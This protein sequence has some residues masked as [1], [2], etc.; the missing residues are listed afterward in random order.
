MTTNQSPRVAFIGS[1][2]APPQVLATGRCLARIVHR[3]G[4]A[5]V[6]GG[7]A[8]FDTVVDG[9][10]GVIVYPPGHKQHTPAHDK[11]MDIVLSLHP[12]PDRARKYGRYLARDVFIIT[13]DA[14]DALVW[15]VVCWTPDGKDS[16]GTGNGIRVANHYNVPV[17]NL[18]RLPW[19]WV[20]QQLVGKQWRHYEDERWRD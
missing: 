20:A 19:Q 12:A 10:P 13:G 4:Y 2:A 7:A 8:G 1:R 15:A 3:A 6:S 14:F 18:H 9:I 16:G 17:F 11:A 5:L